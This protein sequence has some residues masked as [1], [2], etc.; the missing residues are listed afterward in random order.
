[1]PRMKANPLRITKVKKRKSFFL[2]D[3]VNSAKPGLGC[4]SPDFLLNEQEMPLGMKALLVRF[5]FSYSIDGGP[6]K[7]LITMPGTK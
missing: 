3:T 5:S 2:D 6:Y 1:M 4:L 7:N